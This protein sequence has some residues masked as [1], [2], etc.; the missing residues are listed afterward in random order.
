MGPFVLWLASEFS[1]SATL[2]KEQRKGGISPVPF[3]K[4]SCGLAV[5]PKILTS[6]TLQKTYLSQGFRNHLVSPPTLDLWVVLEPHLRQLQSPAVT[7]GSP[8]PIT[9][10]IVP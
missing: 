9:L 8:T 6:E 10:K 4:G 5:F 7:Y 2:A 1:Q 3:L